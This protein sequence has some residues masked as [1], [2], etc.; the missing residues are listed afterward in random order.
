M[1]EFPT[2]LRRLEPQ[3]RGAEADEVRANSQPVLR[4]GGR[5]GA[6][7]RGAGLAGARGPAS[8]G[9][10]AGPAQ[11]AGPQ[12]PGGGRPRGQEASRGPQAGVVIVSAASVPEAMLGP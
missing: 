2:K 8:S 10:D 11:A 6:R 3:P 1:C 5:A 7:H 9:C 12:P 4:A